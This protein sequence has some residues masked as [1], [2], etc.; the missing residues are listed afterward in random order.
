M[1]PWDNLRDAALTTLGIILF[2][3]FIHQPG[4]RKFLSFA[5]L[6][7]SALVAAWSLRNS[8]LLH[9]LGIAKPGRRIW[10]CFLAAFVLG[11]GLGMLTRH[12][13][14]LSLFPMVLGTMALV[15][16]L[17]G[18]TEEIVFRGYI[19]GHL[20]P[21]GRIF[22]ILFASL[23]HTGYKF[24]VISTLS[25]DLRF[26]LSFVVIWTLIGGTTFGI[27]KEFSQSVLPPVLAH[28]LFDIILYG[29]MWSAPLWV[30]S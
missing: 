14:G 1:R 26:D 21:T 12:R 15:S 30:W 28:A 6:A 22:S 4:F 3:L 27:L 7:G 29:G 24:F 13:S 16:P 2:A 25:G 10:H 23:A 11:V 17:I 20:K 18:M 9:A 8:S 19:Q 5:F